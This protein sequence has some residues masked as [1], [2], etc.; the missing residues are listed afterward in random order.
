MVSYTT[1]P[2][3]SHIFPEYLSRYSLFRS[4]DTTLNSQTFWGFDSNASISISSTWLQFYTVL[5]LMTLTVVCPILPYPWRSNHSILPVLRTFP[6]QY[7]L[8]LSES[9]FVIPSFGSLPTTTQVFMKVCTTAHSGFG[10]SFS[11]LTLL[12]LALKPS[13]QELLI[14]LSHMSL[15]ALPLWQKQ[16][17]WQGFCLFVLFSSTNTSLNWN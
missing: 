11:S 13:G 12:V 6:P 10:I 14:C 3:H 4:T 17:Y 15:I 5:L 2:N 9:A 16:N 1:Y 8:S 7:S